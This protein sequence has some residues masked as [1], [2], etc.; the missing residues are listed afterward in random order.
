MSVQSTEMMATLVMHLVVI[1]HEQAMSM[2]TIALEGTIAI[3]Q[4]AQN[5]VVMAIS[6]LANN[7][8]MMQVQ[9]TEMDV[10][11]VV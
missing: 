11:A 2:A 7:V 3:P 10:Q 4:L 6:L 8:K 5:N 9:L 1:A